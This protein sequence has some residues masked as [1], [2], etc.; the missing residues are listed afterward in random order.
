[1]RLAKGEGTVQI[2]SHTSFIFL[3]FIYILLCE[4]AVRL[5]QGRSGGGITGSQ[6]LAF[7]N[8]EQYTI[9]SDLFF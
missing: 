4:L 2:K 3:A 7:R 9:E 5:G 1:M 6:H 8:R